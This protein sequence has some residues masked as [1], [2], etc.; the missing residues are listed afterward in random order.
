M[1]I[2]NDQ[3]N[4]ALSRLIHSD[5]AAVVC[6]WLYTG[7]AAVCSFKRLAAAASDCQQSAST[8]DY[9]EVRR[10]SQRVCEEISMATKLADNVDE[11][12]Q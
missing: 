7:M 12:E 1:P 9:M 8:S 11:L 5:S 4:F 6:W 3:C 10:L 2:A